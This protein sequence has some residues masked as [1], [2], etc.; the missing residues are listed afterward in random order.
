MSEQP[1]DPASPPPV[2]PSNP[3]AP[4]PPPPAAPQYPAPQYPAP[5]QPASA[6]PGY[7]QPAPYGQPAQYPAPTP[8][9]TQPGA[10]GLA[11]AAL[12]IGIASL[13][14]FWVPYLGLLGAIVGLILGIVAWAGAG[15]RNRPKGTAIAGTIISAVAIAAGLVVTIFISVL[16]ARIADC[17]DPQLNDRQQQQCVDNKLNDFFG[18][19]QFSQ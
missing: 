2:P 5:P 10:G 19:D 17:A 11:I 1:P 18:T 3:F 6:P 13:V 9:P 12:I 7:G 15:K 16:I 8:P 4:P 14:L